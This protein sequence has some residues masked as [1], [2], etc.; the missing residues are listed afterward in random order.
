MK[1]REK[2]FLVG[3]GGHCKSCIDVIEEENR[4]DIKGIIDIPEKLG[5]EILGY[6][7]I[8]TDDELPDLAKQGYNFIITVGHLGN[9]NLRTKLFNIIRENGGKLPIII[10]P[11]AQVS[12]YSKIEGGTIIMHHTII[13]TDAQIGWNCIINNKAL[14][15]HDC[16]IGDN[17]HISTG[18]I[19]NGDCRVDTN[20]LIG[21]SSVLKQSTSICSDSIIGAG[22]VVVKNITKP[23]V[24]IGT[25][26]KKIK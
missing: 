2:I 15:E 21:S 7:I 19:I 13:N 16:K 12:K 23:G 11:L 9:P 22:S 4:F 26:A 3:G 1:I 18:A 10:S 24:Y 20:C 6:K 5:N 14:V 17:V 25:P 8:G